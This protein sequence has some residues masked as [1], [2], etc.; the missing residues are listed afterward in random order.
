MGLRAHS[1]PGGKVPSVTFVSGN[2]MRVPLVHSI[3]DEEVANRSEFLWKHASLTSGETGS[4]GYVPFACLCEQSHSEPSAFGPTAPFETFEHP[5]QHSSQL[6]DV[7][8]EHF[9]HVDVPQVR[10]AT[11]LG[12]GSYELVC[13][14]SPLRG[15]SFLHKRHEYPPLWFALMLHATSCIDPV[16][17]TVGFLRGSVAPSCPS[18]V[19]GGTPAPLPSYGMGPPPATPQPEP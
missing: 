13:C 9:L 15:A 8:D 11:H 1:L 7:P 3:H 16:F 6:H 12:R 2:S 19:P 18:F 5:S 17:H 14:T 4:G 10:S